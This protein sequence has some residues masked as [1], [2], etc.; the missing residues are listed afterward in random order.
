MSKMSDLDLLVRSGE[1]TADDFE[2]RGFSKEDARAMASLVEAG[3]DD[4]LGDFDENGDA[5]E[6]PAL[7][8]P[9]PEPPA[10]LPARHP[11]RRK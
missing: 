11:H 3:E 8:P 2:K 9:A 1:R 5:Y 7:K 6:R 10:Y 4:I